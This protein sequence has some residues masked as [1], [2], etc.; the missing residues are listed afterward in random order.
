MTVR[1]GDA[2][3]FSQRRAPYEHTGYEL[4]EAERVVPRMPFRRHRLVRRFSARAFAL[5]PKG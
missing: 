2:G 4:D 3:R 1:I 5:K